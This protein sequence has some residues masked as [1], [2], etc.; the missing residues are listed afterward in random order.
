MAFSIFYNAETEEYSSNGQCLT[1]S[2]SF[3]KT[4]M[5]C[6]MSLKKW[7]FVKR[8]WKGKTRHK[9]WP[10]Q[11]SVAVRQ[12]EEKGKKIGKNK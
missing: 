3:F 12:R 10:F 6:R 2:V 7:N 4:E 11:V 1:Q 5:S 8:K 9:L